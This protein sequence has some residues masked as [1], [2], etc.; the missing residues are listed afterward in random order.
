M[1]ESYTPSCP[2]NTVTNVFPWGPG[3]MLTHWHTYPILASWQPAGAEGRKQVGTTQEHIQS[4][5]HYHYN[6]LLL[7]V[8]VDGKWWL[9]RT[10][11]VDLR[12]PGLKRLRSRDCSCLMWWQEEAGLLF[13]PLSL[14]RLGGGHSESRPAPDSRVLS[15]SQ[16]APEPS[17]PVL[18]PSPAQPH[19]ANNILSLRLL[20]AG[21]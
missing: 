16:P 4:A 10:F 11:G 21:G 6:A 5:C 19:P 14:A 20:S 12:W 2:S 18:P 7:W 8:N 3:L 1:I 13:W 15:L 17:V 9:S